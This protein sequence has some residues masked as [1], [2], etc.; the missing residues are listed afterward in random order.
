M[1]RPTSAAITGIDPPLRTIT[2]AAPVARSIA[3]AH[4]STAG[5]SAS[6]YAGSPGGHGSSSSSAWGGQ[7]VRSIRS[8][9]APIASASCPGASRT[10][11]DARASGAMLVLCSSGSPA[12]TECTVSEGRVQV[13]S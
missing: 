7:A 3:A 6:M 8:S 12:P 4:A 9:T 11:S 10:E 5:S 1:P 2:G 13:R